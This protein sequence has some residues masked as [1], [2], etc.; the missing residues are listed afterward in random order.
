[1]NSAL[2]TRS[3]AIGY[4][5]GHPVLSDLKLSLEAGRIAVLIGG[6]GSGKSTLLR[7]IAGSLR[8]LEGRF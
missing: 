1:M 6:N 5:P 2:I 7:T 8:P 4:S 3:L